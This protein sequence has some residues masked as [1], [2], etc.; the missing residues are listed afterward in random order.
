M[1]ADPEPGNES[2]TGATFSDMQLRYITEVKE[3]VAV[4]DEVADKEADNHLDNALMALIISLLAQETSQLLLYKSPVMYYLAICSISPQTKR[5]YPS[6][7]YTIY[8]AHI[9]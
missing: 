7:Q 8:L 2:K 3:A 5:F 9:I 6:F 4:A 1:R